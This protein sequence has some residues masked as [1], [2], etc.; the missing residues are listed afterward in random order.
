MN[1]SAISPRTSLGR[2]LRAPL[3]WIPSEACFPILQGRL[4]GK[5]WIV[6][7]G[8][9]GF[10]L[11][12][13][14]WKQQSVF[15]KLVEPASI[16]FDIGAHVGFYT[17]LASVLVGP[18]GRVFAFEPVPANIRYLR[19]HLDLNNIKNVTVIEAAI[20]DRRG[21]A[22]FDLGPSRSMGHFS[23]DGRLQVETLALDD[24]LSTGKL[25]V[26]DH[27][28][29]DVEGAEVMVLSGAKRVLAEFRPTLYLSTDTG[30]THKQC[31]RLLASLGFEL[32]P[33]DGKNL[34]EAYEI[35]ACRKR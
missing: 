27:I 20:A 22:C 17:L 28:K 11:G 7:S 2:A 26:P 5:K 29:I 33:I 23:S 16:V 1:F 32:Q 35:L 34:D 31:C 15:E 12:S 30:D 9:H 25:P 3:R 13:Y 18:A 6:G 8:Q 14:E 10:W 4:R 24:L 21:S 19:R